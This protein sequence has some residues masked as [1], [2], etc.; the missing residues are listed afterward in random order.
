MHDHSQE[1]MA[2][3]GVCAGPING[4]FCVIGARLLL[5]PHCLACMESFCVCSTLL[6]ADEDESGGTV[7][8]EAQVC[9]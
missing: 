8:L 9:D 2:K 4:P 3:A 1:H 6:V 7:P 5:D